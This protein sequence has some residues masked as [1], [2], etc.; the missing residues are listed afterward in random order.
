MENFLIKLWKLGTSVIFFSPLPHF[1]PTF[2]IHP[3][4][5]ANRDPCR[6]PHGE[7]SLP[8]LSIYSLGLWLQ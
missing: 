7:V 5:P 4:L 6:E 2:L 8:A 1:F 3:F